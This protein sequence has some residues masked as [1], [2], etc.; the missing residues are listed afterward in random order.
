MRCREV[1][2]ALTAY[3]D[4]EVMPSERR[5]IEAHLAGCGSC[6][7]ELSGLSSTRSRL[8]DSLSTMAAAAAP[9]SQALSH[10]QDRIVE[11]VR[12]PPATRFRRKGDRRMKMRWR[13]AFGTLGAI[14]LAAAIIGGVPST[15]AAAG[16]FFATVFHIGPADQVQFGY[17]PEGFDAQ[18]AFMTGSAMSDDGPAVQQ[19]QTVYQK[20]DQFIAVTTSD[21]TDQALPEGQS[22]DVNGVSAVL[23][24]GLSGTVGGP[25]PGMPK[26]GITTNTPVS[27][28]AGP[29]IVEGG[30]VQSAGEGPST[31]SA[32]GAEPSTQTAGKGPAISPI[33]YDNANSLTWN[34]D[35]TKVEVLT[36]LSVDELQKIAEG[37]VL[38]E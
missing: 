16:Q 9:S 7:R 19:Q 27:G 37:L 11:E 36:N 32:G 2:K 25:G 14:V 17:L 15:R 12:T 33:T 26:D 28:V 21:G 1:R 5:L 13:I 8:T 18:P 38:P 4:A 22:A 20:G 35:G 23:R 34:L 29:V 10:L 6:E 30:N 24:T 3:L 31:Q